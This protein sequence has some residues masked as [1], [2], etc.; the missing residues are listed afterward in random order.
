MA[1]PGKL[2][3]LNC[4]INK[5]ALCFWNIGT[6]PFTL[7]LLL[8]TT[9]KQSFIQKTPFHITAGDSQPC[10]ITRSWTYCL[11]LKTLNWIRTNVRQPSIGMAIAFVFGTDHKLPSSSLLAV[12]S[13]AVTA[14]ILRRS[15]KYTS[16]I[17]KAVCLTLIAPQL[18]QESPAYLFNL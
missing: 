1:I 15:S 7:N 2:F 9:C 16:L 18:W 6:S 8:F 10:S 4:L 3:T 17:N 11:L 14:V 13:W 5:N 12:S